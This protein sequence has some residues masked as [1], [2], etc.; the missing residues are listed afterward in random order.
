MTVP[1][2]LIRAD[3]GGV[4]G[5]G[6]VMRCLALAQ[7][8][9]DLGGRAIF[10]M[11]ESTPAIRRRLLSESCEVVP[12]AAEPGTDDDSQ[13]TVALALER[14]ARWVV[15]DG[16]CFG[17]EFQL[18]LKRAGLKALL[19]DDYGHAKSYSA[20]LVLN[21]N[22]PAAPAL[23]EKREAG[24]GL[25]LGPRYCLLRREFLANGQQKREIP[26]TANRGL[27]TMGGSDPA[28][29]TARVL[30]ALKLVTLDNL[31]VIVVV[32]GSNPEYE[33][34]KRSVL[35]PSVGSGMDVAL[36]RD[37]SDMAELMAW[38]DVAVSAAGSTCWE[39]CFFGVPSLLIDAADNQTGVARELNRLGCAVHLGNSV[40]VSAAKIAQEL[41]RVVRSADIRRSLSERSRQLVE[42]SGARRVAAILSCGLHLRQAGESDARLLWEWANE[43]ETRSNS[44][45]SDA[46]PWETHI[47]W[48]TEK[49]SQ[50]DCLLFI[51]E[52]ESGTPV[53]QIRFDV[54]Q[55]G[56][57][58]VNVSVAR[59]R[60]G[61]GL[62]TRL[63]E[64]G[65]ERALGN[66]GCA[67]I[68][69]LVKLENTASIKA[70]EKA[71]FVRS[72]ME[73][74]RGNTAHHFILDRDSRDQG[75]V[76]HVVEAR[77]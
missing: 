59:E 42:G 2:L 52:D 11:A 76:T 33:S 37:V 16:Y 60:R 40:D 4:I 13:R 58:Y 36:H 75:I 27:V 28:N 54:S 15:L 26:A 23:Y 57:T 32:G 73:Q 53:G 7:A 69:A 22:V 31:S 67:R 51:G 39:L 5:T 29:L 18:A 65:A 14:N 71:G 56:E 44:F 30:E 25:L 48:L 70:F 61:Q 8:W 64:L 43:R 46:I 41:E 19:L 72:G 21:Q 10:A 12:V 1:S 50:T 38:A 55:N 3:A 9:Q 66:A 77:S 20:D 63:I 34:L 49:L 68:H 17:A 45:A 6:H 47:A 35:E 74:V 62:A 24:T